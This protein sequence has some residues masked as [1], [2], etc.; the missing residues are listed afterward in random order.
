LKKKENEK[1]VYLQAA[2]L[3]HS[4][5]AQ[6]LYVANETIDERTLRRWHVV[7][8]TRQYA[9]HRANVLKLGRSLGLL[10]LQ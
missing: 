9:K 1:L 7:I 10:T 5:R 8:A 6:I 2:F 4:K 3:I